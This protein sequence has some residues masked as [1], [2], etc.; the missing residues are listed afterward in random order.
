[1]RAA[2]AVLAVSLLS[3]SPASADDGP[4]RP[5]DSVRT[6]LEPGQRRTISF[7]GVAGTPL[8]LRA[9]AARGSRVAP[10]VTLLD[11][12]GAPAP[13]GDAN[14]DAGRVARI[15]GFVFGATGV[16]RIVLDSPT[17]GSLTLTTQ[18]A[19]RR[20]LDWSSADGDERT[21]DAAPGGDVSI[22]LT[23]DGDATIEL[24][25]PSGVRVARAAARGGRARIARTRL[26]ELG[27]YVIRVEGAVGGYVARAIVRP[28]GSRRREFRDVEAP[29]DVRGFAPGTA[30]NQSLVT[31]DFDGTGFTSRQTIA[32]LKDGEVVATAD[33][34]TGLVP[35]ATA[36]VDLGE[37]PPGTYSI[38]IR[39]PGRPATAVPGELA[40]TNLSPR[41]VTD[42]V[43]S[44]P[45]TGEFPVTVS[46]SGFDADADVVVGPA[47]G[48]AALPVT[49]VRRRSHESIDAIVTPP[50][51]FTGPCDLEVRDQDGHS[52]LLPDAFDVLGYRAAPAA[53]ETV[54]EGAAI[55]LASVA[56]D[57]SRDRVLAAFRRGP[58]A[59]SFV[60]F[61]AK[62]LAQIDRLD[63]AASDLGGGVF[64]E[65]Q[66]ARDEVGDT[67][68]LCLTTS[69]S[70]TR[71]VVRI[72]SAA[73][74]R[75][76]LAEQDLAAASA[77]AVSRVHAAPDRGA[78]G[79]LVVWDE[80]ESQFG[81]RIWARS[82]SAA[83]VFASGAPSL[84][85]WDALGETGHPTA[86]WQ[87]DGA[88]LVAWAGLSE[89][90]V[91]YAIRMTT[92]DAA[93]VPL[94]G[95]T[96]RIAATSRKWNA[97]ARPSLAVNPADG[98]TLLTYWY[99]DGPI[100]RPAARGIS[101]DTGAPLVTAL[102]DEGL[103][104]D[105]GVPEGAVWNAAR[106]E[107]VVATVGYDARVAVRRLSADGTLRTS[108]RTELY[109]GATAA[110][111]AGPA[112]TLGL[113][114][115]TDAVDDGVF[116]KKTTTLRALAG[117]LR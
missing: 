74:I 114:R 13:A 100:Y 18:R 11:P 56:Y 77:Q 115:V 79:Y 116:D 85:V 67:F 63:V 52:A 89:D 32:V 64:D 5:G 27:R 48:G 19:E 45:N 107:F 16:W 51:Y 36:L 90:R 102:L 112:G 106:G 117:P 3:V 66:A 70:P 31:I 21:F 92:T 75:Q 98:A 82:V 57:E 54:T 59:A 26:P 23:A 15:D 34:R 93:G 109:E 73:D 95:A 88:F 6:F 24:L 2:A 96:P 9:V 47:G 113:L 87:R 29:P 1:M 43:D 42:D 104:F 46:G 4:L 108:V 55:G 7:A 39:R 71:A 80:F 49:I 61:D 12:S 99:G 76:P 17:R 58:D 111:Y 101:P 86:A 91:A 78:G 72:V 110:P 94:P 10:R 41:I 37:V 25:A 30:P 97:A 65:V 44:A 62:S 69:A 8:D 33:V 20:R 103:A 50:P 40:V 53:V 38:E 35:G 81:S 83:G 105:G 68:A 84:V 60:L 14:P 22:A 28:A